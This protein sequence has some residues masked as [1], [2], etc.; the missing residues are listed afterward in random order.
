MLTQ[1]KGPQKVGKLAK[2]TNMAKVKILT[3]FGQSC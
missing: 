3:T 2:A 1:L